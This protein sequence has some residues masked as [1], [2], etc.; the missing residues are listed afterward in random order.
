[1]FL[2][3]KRAIKE[4]IINSSNYPVMETE[5]E[6]GRSY[7]TPPLVRARGYVC[8]V[9]VCIRQIYL[10]TSSYKYK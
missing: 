2:N 6:C 9:F 5:A 3:M 1:M 8:C 4:R 10:P 7:R